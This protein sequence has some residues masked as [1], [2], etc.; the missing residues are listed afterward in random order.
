MSMYS[1][2][3]E[4]RNANQHIECIGCREESNNGTA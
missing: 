3:V 1:D 4:N 2:A